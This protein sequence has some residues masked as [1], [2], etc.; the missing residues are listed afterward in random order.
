MFTQKHTFACVYIYIYRER[1][2][3][4]YIYKY[5]ILN[6]MLRSWKRRVLSWVDQYGSSNVFASLLHRQSKL[7][8]CSQFVLVIGHLTETRLCLEI[9]LITMCRF[10]WTK[11]RPWFL[12]WNSYITIISKF[13]YI[14]SSLVR[15]P[16]GVFENHTCMTNRCE[17]IF[18][19]I[20]P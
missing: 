17:I 16:Y 11:T 10:L 7:S 18:P 15:N 3:H 19:R 1:D 13:L 8:S 20:W 6:S 5:R 14:A 12:V 4:I 9:S 2:K